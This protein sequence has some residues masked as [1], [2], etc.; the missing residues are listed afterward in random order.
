MNYLYFLLLVVVVV[1]VLLMNFQQQIDV[2]YHLYYSMLV[3]VE[4]YLRKK[5]E[6]NKE[7]EDVFNL[8]FII[9]ARCLGIFI[10]D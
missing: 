2:Q 5:N 6:I 3:V 10:A 1:V 8:L 4:S 9:G 7:N